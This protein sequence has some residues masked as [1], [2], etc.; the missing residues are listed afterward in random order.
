MRL[1]LIIIIALN[2]LYASWEYLRPVVGSSAPA[3]L[4]DNLNR[5]ELLNERKQDQPSDDVLASAPA[6]A[7]LSEEVEGEG[8]SVGVENAGEEEKRPEPQS[9]LASSAC[10]TLGPFK[11]EDIMQQLR[12]S[13]AEHVVEVEV[14]KRQQLEKHRYWV[15]L[16]GLQ[17][18][19]A[20]QAM[21]KKLRSKGIKDFYIVLSG[22]NKHSISLGHYRE[23]NH[24]N[25]RVKRVIALGFEAEI[26]VIYREY[27]IYWL[28][29]KVDESEAANEFSVDEHITEGISKLD[30]EC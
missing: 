29:Y 15:Y 11:N 23:P 7:N 12:E 16:P 2:V 28:D 20:S 6:L 26:D 9:Q 30:R 22:K 4:P 5:L 13:L 25:R 1:L 14:R 10:Y 24:A 18:R 17:N 8:S 21:S 27:D 19:K 3:A